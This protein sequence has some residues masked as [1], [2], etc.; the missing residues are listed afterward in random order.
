M[1]GFKYSQKLIP[2]ELGLQFLIPHPRPHQ[3]ILGNCKHLVSESCLTGSYQCFS[4][5]FVQ[6][7]QAR[8]HVLPS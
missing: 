4:V 5:F 6:L 1:M 8:L 2:H 3:L 7:L